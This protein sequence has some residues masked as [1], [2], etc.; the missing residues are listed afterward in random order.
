MTETC[1]AIDPT[2]ICLNPQF[3][4]NRQLAGVVWQN[5]SMSCR[6][7]ARKVNAVHLELNKAGTGTK[8]ER[9]ERD[10]CFSSFRAALISDLINDLKNIVGAT[11]IKRQEQFPI[12]G[13]GD[14]PMLGATMR[15]STN[16]SLS[17]CRE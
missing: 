15:P 16:G 7:N 17:T 3:C 10:C 2:P 9:R 1:C 11:V 14:C 8:N 12:V 13:F 5:I 4:R 6:T